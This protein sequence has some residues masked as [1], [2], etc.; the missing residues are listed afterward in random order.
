MVKLEI[1]HKEVIVMI[2]DYLSE[3]NLTASLLAL[4][5]ETQIL[6]NKYS[7]EISF[8]RSLI[9]EGNWAQ[10]ENLLK[11]VAQKGQFELTRGMF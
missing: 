9:L 3:N 8:L 10:V 6:L 5:K 2:L 1:A 11:A 4:E 7:S